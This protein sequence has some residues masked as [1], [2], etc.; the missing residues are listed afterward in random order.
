MKNVT[1]I[2]A[3]FL[4]LSLQ[5]GTFS[6]FSQGDTLYLTTMV[7][8]C[9]AHGAGLNVDGICHAD[10]MTANY[11]TE[12]S[13]SVSIISTQMACFD[14]TLKPMVFEL[15]L[16]QNRVASEAEVLTLRMYGEEVTIKLDR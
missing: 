15:S 1:I 6:A 3:M 7:D 13:A 2:L 11:A 4:S 10:R 16:D 8:S 9:N 14:Q 12:C 5:A